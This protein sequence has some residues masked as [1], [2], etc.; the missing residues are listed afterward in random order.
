LPTWAVWPEALTSG[1]EY[2]FSSMA[3]INFIFP[4]DTL[5]S[6]ILFIVYF[7]TTFYMVKIFL[8]IFNYFRGSGKLEM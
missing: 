5:F 8:M 1:L 4:I 7:E 6:V 2:I 3:L